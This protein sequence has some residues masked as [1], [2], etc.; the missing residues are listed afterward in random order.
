VNSTDTCWQGGVGRLSRSVESLHDII[1]RSRLPVRWDENSSWRRCGV[2]V[3]EMQ[4]SGNFEQSKQFVIDRIIPAMKTR[5][6]SGSACG[7]AG[8]AQD[9]E[10]LVYR[11]RRCVLKY[12]EHLFRNF[13]PEQFWVVEN[14]TQFTSL[15][16]TRQNSTVCF[17]SGLAVWVGHL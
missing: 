10:R 7:Q 15:T 11:S 5:L 3:G 1:T 17:A 9:V 12:C 16:P 4:F 6:E 8:A 14:I 13:C 2:C